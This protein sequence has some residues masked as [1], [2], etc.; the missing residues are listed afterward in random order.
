M[1][2]PAGSCR[3]L[4]SCFYPFLLIDVTFSSYT[5]VQMCAWASIQEAHGDAKVGL[6]RGMK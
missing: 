4:L 2:M 6:L 1:F 5:Q 3:I